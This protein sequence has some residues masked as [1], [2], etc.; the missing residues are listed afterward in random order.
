[1]QT[2]I[3]IYM[4][5]KIIID[6]VIYT[7]VYVWKESTLSLSIYFMIYTYKHITIWVPQRAAR[8]GPFEGL[9]R[10]GPLGKSSLVY[11]LDCLSAGLAYLHT[12]RPELETQT[13]IMLAL[14]RST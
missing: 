1:M 4:I 2:W 6:I 10:G 7:E 12:V 11:R 14:A 13:Q 9:R 5:L 8:H 3:P